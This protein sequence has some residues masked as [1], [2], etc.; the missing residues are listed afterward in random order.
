M[1]NFLISDL[2]NRDMK[3]LGSSVLDLKRDLFAL[4]LRHKR[5]A[6]ENPRQISKIK[7]D[8]ARLKTAIAMKTISLKKG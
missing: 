5:K 2:L 4:R 7:K 6:L 1:T 3:S 8:I